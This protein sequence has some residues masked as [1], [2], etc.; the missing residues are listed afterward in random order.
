M[1][2]G[3]QIGK[4]ARETG[5]SA[6]TIRFYQK[7]GLLKE[8]RRSEGG[9]RLFSPDDLE[10]LIFIRKAQQ[11]GFSL[12]EV[13]ELLI[14]R[15]GKTQA[16]SHVRDLLGQKLAAVEKKIQELR[17]LERELQ[18]ALRKCNREIRKETASHEGCCPVLEEI[19]RITKYQEK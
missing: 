1:S 2:Q 13:R 12:G 14:V 9:F 17:E 10:T 11:L 4:L 16:C 18:V 6:D 15:N 8:P 19:G 5:L 7:Q 3:I